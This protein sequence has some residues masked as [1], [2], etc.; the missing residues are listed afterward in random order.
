VDNYDTNDHPKAFDLHITLAMAVAGLRAIVEAFGREHTASN[1][2][3]SNGCVYSTADTYT[4][5]LTPV[6]IVGQWLHNIGALRAAS[7][8]S[9]GL[10]GTCSPRNEFWDRLDALGIRVDYD[11]QTFL[12]AAQTEQDNGSDWGHALDRALSKA[13]V[14]QSEKVN[15]AAAAVSSAQFEQD[16]AQRILDLLS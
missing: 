6:C 2:T 11:A 16:A 4:G 9:G 5:F 15:A 13:R 7:Y 3:D 10:Y 8:N 12:R 14:A 1:G